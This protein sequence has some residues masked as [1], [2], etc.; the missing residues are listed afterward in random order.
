MSLSFVV[1][2]N[3]LLHFISTFSCPCQTSQRT[4]TGQDRLDVCILMYWSDDTVAS[5]FF[6]IGQHRSNHVEPS[7]GRRSKKRRRKDAASAQEALEDPTAMAPPPAPVAAPDAMAHLTIGLNSTTRR[8]ESTS[9]SRL[10]KTAPL[11][12]QIQ[13]K[14]RSTDDKRVPLASDAERLAAVF[15]VRSSQS[16]LLHAH[17]PLL[18]KTSS[19][20]R[21]PA[22]HTRL[23]PLPNTAEA[24]LTAAL[25]LP[26]VGVVGLTEDCP[27]AEPLLDYVRQHVPITDVPWLEEASAGTYLP[28]E[29]KAVQTSAPVPLKNKNLPQRTPARKR[30]GSHEAE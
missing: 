6:P 15:V 28:V 25:A 2:S 27:H 3:S 26:R 4:L 22:S 10:P 20:G 14:K 11:V 23:V 9:R 8:M 18:A 17:L 5:L 16:S 30:K 12:L 19:L 29:I 21:L 24:R 1:L 13:P 7:K